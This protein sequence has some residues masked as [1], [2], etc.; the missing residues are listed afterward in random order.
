[1]TAGDD[2]SMG[3]CGFCIAGFVKSR[4]HHSLGGQVISLLRNKLSFRGKRGGGDVHG[5]EEVYCL[6]LLFGTAPFFGS[7]LARGIL[8]LGLKGTVIFL[9][10]VCL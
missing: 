9:V 3:L 2:G 4:A 10:Y 8:V 7:C 1:M 5:K 6:V